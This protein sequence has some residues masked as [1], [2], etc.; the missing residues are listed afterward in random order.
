M[1]T[2]G[3]IGGMAWPSTV[4]YYQHINRLITQK[5]GPEHCAT[6][7]L[8]Q[9][10][11]DQI[12]AWGDNDQWDKVGEAVVSLTQQLERAGAD[13]FVIAC[14]TVHGTLPPII[15][16]I[17]LPILHIVDATSK[18]IQS[19]GFQTVGLIGSIQTMTGDYFRGRLLDNYGITAITPAKEQQEMLHETLDHEL[20]RGIFT[21][22]AKVKFQKV[23][24]D[25]LAQG[26]E[27]IIL[28][29]TEFGLLLD[30]DKSPVPM[31]DTLVQH[32]E[33]TVELALSE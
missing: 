10:D 15:S 29:C 5:L 25:L 26:C 31:I 14:N 16:S 28:G 7:V 4:S 2:I 21:D 12:K 32:T 33:A 23:I 1:K 30:A 24:D 3:V 6:L 18:K 11:F 20:L 9:T 27:A 13:F 8:V 19:Y 22:E 17:N